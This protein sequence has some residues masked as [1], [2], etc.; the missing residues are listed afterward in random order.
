V[1][2]DSFF[3]NPIRGRKI[4]KE[5]ERKREKGRKRERNGWMDVV[6]RIVNSARGKH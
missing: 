3:V 6:S 5:R 1:S 2:V 4:E